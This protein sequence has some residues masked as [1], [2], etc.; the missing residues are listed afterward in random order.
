MAEEERRREEY[1]GAEHLGGDRGGVNYG[2]RQGANGRGSESSYRR[3]AKPAHLSSLSS[4]K[5]HALY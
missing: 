2:D 4:L 3:S 1:L 5:A